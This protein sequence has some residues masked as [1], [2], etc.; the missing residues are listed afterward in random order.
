MSNKFCIFCGE[1]P[2][3]KTKEHVIPEWLI[4]LTGS[5]SRLAGFGY[6]FTKQ[7]KRIFAF[8]S[9]TFP[10][11]NKCNS[12]FSALEAKTKTIIEKIL[13]EK[14]VDACEW[15]IVFTWFDKVRIGLWL[16]Y[17]CLN[18]K[19]DAISPKFHIEN[20]VDVSDR[21]LLIY[22]TNDIQKG[23]AFSGVGLPSFDFVPSCFGMRINQFF[24]VNVSSAFLLSRRL[25]LPYPKSM[26][27]EGKKM[28]VE[29]EEGRGYQLK[30]LFNVPHSQACIEL[31][32]PVCSLHDSSLGDSPYNNDYVRSYIDIVKSKIGSVLIKRRDGA[33]LYVKHDSLSWIPPKSIDKNKIMGIGAETVFVLQNYLNDE[34]M[35]YDGLSKFQKNFIRKLKALNKVIIGNIGQQ[36]I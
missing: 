33:E 11:C 5:P 2:H 12:Y 26:K 32:Q 28:S 29:L 35:K 8:D 24:F 10:A 31:Y 9:F 13:L 4:R 19:R 25:G 34:A 27:E 16:G 22:K 23:V 7:S 30:P 36:S 3:E 15:S 18:N 1:P 17:L 20:R 6:D 14:S 21:M